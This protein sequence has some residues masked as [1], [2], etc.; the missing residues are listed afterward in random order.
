M[1]KNPRLIAPPKK[2][3]KKAVWHSKEGVR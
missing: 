3:G 1:L 2:G